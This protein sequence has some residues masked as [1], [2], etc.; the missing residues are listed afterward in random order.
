M[1][2]TRRELVWSLASGAYAAG[3]SPVAETQCG[4]VQGASI[5]GVH[6]FRGI[7][8]GAPA[9]FL[10]PSK[11]ARWT[12]TRDATQAGP[13]CIQ[14]PGNIF[15]SPLIGEYFAGGR[16]DRV[17]LSTRTDSENCLN[18]NVLTTGLS[19]RRPVMVYIH[20]GGLTGGSDALTLFSDRFVREQNIVL[21]GVNHRLNVFGY[22][23]LGAFSPKYQ[24]G[25]VGQLDLIA[26]L[27][28]VRDNI[29]GFGGDPQ[30]VTIFGESGGGQKISA[31]MAIPAAKGL[32]HKACIQSGAVL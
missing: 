24:I 5:E 20:G 12:G 28:W 30:N 27:E 1:K 2:L 4:R 23:W 32:F 21:V 17:Q 8:Y 11:P 9:R 14:G 25:N 31:L 15:R 3:K 16:P 29:A 10:P 13:R 7:P 6:I 18:L 26:A 22:A 19:G